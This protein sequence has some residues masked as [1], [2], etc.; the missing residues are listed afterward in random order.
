MET[1][2][3][4]KENI[5]VPEEKLESSVMEPTN[6][7]LAEL[8]IFL[9]HF[10]DI[11]FELAEIRERFGDS[12][13]APADPLK[14]MKDE[15]SE[16]KKGFSEMRS[17]IEELKNKGIQSGGNTQ[18]PQQQN[19]GYYQAPAMP[20]ITAPMMPFYQTP[21]FQPIIPAMPNFNMR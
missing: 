5:D 8:E 15:L 16:I 9:K 17:V 18:I 10:E 2:E 1:E 20:A 14:E 7:Q 21:N 13:E 3:E 11:K 19:G 6:K 4:K 12:G